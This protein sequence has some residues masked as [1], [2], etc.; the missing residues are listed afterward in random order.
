MPCWIKLW[1]LVAIPYNESV[2]LAQ[3]C[4]LLM[5]LWIFRRKKACSTPSGLQMTQVWVIYLYSSRKWFINNINFIN[6]MLAMLIRNFNCFAILTEITFG[7]IWVWI[8]IGE[9]VLLNIKSLLFILEAAGLYS[10]LFQQDI[11][12]RLSL[13]SR[14]WKWNWYCFSEK[15]LFN[16]ERH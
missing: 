4:E 15:A 10:E 8:D 14:I 7:V 13:T 5:S 9:T 6:F 3:R 16:Y 12:D 11:S 2:N 1:A